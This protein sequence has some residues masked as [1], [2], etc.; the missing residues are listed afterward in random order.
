MFAHVAS[1]RIMS[2][3]RRRFW[4]CFAPPSL[5]WQ[6]SELTGQQNSHSILQHPTA[7]SSQNLRQN[8]AIKGTNEPFIHRPYDDVTHVQLQNPA[9]SPFPPLWNPC[10]VDFPKPSVS[11]SKSVCQGIPHSKSLRY[12]GSNLWNVVKT[13]INHPFGMVYYWFTHIYPH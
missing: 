8:G 3:C 5:H 2:P 6:M 1:C 10:V 12:K 4:R 7:E 9:Q 11:P 13:I